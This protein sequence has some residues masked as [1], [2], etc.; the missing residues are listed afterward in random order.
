M[1][2]RECVGMKC[3]KYKFESKYEI[4]IEHKYEI[5]IEYK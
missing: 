3:M 2:E 4:Q 1:S 5:Q